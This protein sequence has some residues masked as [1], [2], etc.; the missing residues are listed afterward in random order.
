[1]SKVVNLLCIVGV[2][3][4]VRYFLG[5]PIHAPPTKWVQEIIA[6]Y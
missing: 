6:A 4:A 2:D 3:P 1:M 5:P